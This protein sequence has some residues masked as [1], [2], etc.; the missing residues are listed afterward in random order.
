MADIEEKCLDAFQYD[1]KEVALELLSEV[2]QPQNVKSDHKWTLLHYAAKY[3]W[4]DICQALIQNHGLDPTDKTDLG[5]STFH[6]ACLYGKPEVV[7]Y[8]LTLDAM[9][10]IVNDEDNHG[11]SA[12]YMACTKK[13][14]QVIKM[15]LKEDSIIT[16]TKRLPSD[17]FDVLLLLSSKMDW[18]TEFC[19][20][21]YF[22]VFMAGNS[23]AG[24]TTLTNVMQKLTVLGPAR[25]HDPVTEV[26]ALTA[27]VYPTQCSG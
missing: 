9:L 27:G 21:P 23:A 8:M 3:G 10:S 16:P 11:R 20:N 15:L 12:L 2:H 25:Q 6:V 22:R 13:H 14:L 7:E 26:K 1:E 18:N 5:Y 19:I 24:K 17:N 4:G